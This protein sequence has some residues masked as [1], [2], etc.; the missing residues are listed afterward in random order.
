MKTAHLCLFE[1]TITYHL[2]TYLHLLQEIPSEK[3]CKITVR[4]RYLA[5]QEVEKRFNKP[6]KGKIS[7]M[8]TCQ[9][10]RK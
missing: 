1:D 6:G 5:M 4:S 7:Y 8:P 3:P 2:T 10:A 9:N